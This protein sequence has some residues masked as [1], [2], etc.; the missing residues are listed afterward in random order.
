MTD[1]KLEVPRPAPLKG[2]R[3][4]DFT[5]VIAGPYC[6]YQL[7]LLGADVI[8][9]ERPGIGDQTR[10]RSDLQGIPGLTAE[11][12][13]QNAAKRSIQIDLHKPQGLALARKLV[14]SC[15]VMLENYTPGVAERIGLGYEAMKALNPKMIY[16]SLSGYGQDG[17]FSRR[18]AYDHVIQGASGI[19]MITGTPETVPNR[20]GPPMFDYIAGI[21]GAFAILA[22]IKERDRTGLGQRLDVAM[23]D[24]ALVSM[25]SFSS[26]HLNG[27]RDVVANGNTAG[28]GSP[29]SGIF[30]TREG[31]LAV[32]ANNARQ[33]KQFCGALGEPN[34][35]EDARFCTPELRE[36]NPKL[37]GQAI[38]ERL[39][40]RTAAEWEDAMAQAHVP[41]ARVRTLNEVLHEPQ[42]IARG[43]QQEMIDPQS[44]RPVFVPT[45]GFKWNGEPLGPE[46]MPP[47]LGADADAILAE[48]GLEEAEIAALRSEG[49]VLAP[50]PGSS[51]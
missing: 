5:A 42:V 23:L 40:T 38:I 32:A 14:S 26:R 27:G 16:A 25:A 34:L 46:R 35:L 3:L 7:A 17:P 4:I 33:V 37:F 36:K 29:A 31:M 8:K 20:M 28:S 30:P 15:D 6:T 39:A 13:A 10:R 9:V 1:T 21:Y 44:G 19:T 18:P 50:A 51:S 43:V 45:I 24:A 2:V 49:V 11:F 22:A 47:R 12:V 41:A 48:I